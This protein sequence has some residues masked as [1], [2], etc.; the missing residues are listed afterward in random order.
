[1]A[2]LPLYSRQ[3][4]EGSVPR[5]RFYY[6]VKGVFI[7]SFHGTLKRNRSGIANSP[8]KDNLRKDAS[9]NLGKRTQ[10]KLLMTSW[11]R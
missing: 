5:S 4:S 1:M 7:S 6:R 3:L 11:E 2:V 9:L 8:L 10:K